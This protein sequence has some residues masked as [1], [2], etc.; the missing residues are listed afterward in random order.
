[1]PINITWNET[2]A[3]AKVI[4]LVK[5]NLSGRKVVYGN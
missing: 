1:M 5:A 4:A 3:M 2:T